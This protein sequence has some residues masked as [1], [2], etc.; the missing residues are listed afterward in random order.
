[1]CVCVCV[2]GAT[3]V[4][5]DGSERRCEKEQRESNLVQQTWLKLVSFFLPRSNLLLAPISNVVF[6]F[7]FTRPLYFRWTYILFSSPQSWSLTGYWVY[8]IAASPFAR[9]AVA[10]GTSTLSIQP[11][12]QT[13]TRIANGHLQFQKGK[14]KSYYSGR[15]L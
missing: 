2:Q 12:I 6:C 11:L 7:L 3:F 15:F 1:V 8:C 14:K 9:I 4:C 5:I 13:H 10:A